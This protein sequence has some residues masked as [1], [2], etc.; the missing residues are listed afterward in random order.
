MIAQWALSRLF[1]ADLLFLMRAIIIIVLLLF[2]IQLTSLFAIEQLSLELGHITGLKWRA[3]Q[4]QLRFVL[5]S[6]S[7]D[8]DRFHISIGKIRHPLLAS[9]LVGT[10]IECS[11]G[12]VTQQELKCEQGSTVVNHSA[13]D[14][15]RLPMTF[16]WKYRPQ[17]IELKFQNIRFLDGKVA[18]SIRLDK[19]SWQGSLRGSELD[20]AKSQALAKEIADFSD[21][22]LSS[23]GSLNLMLNLAGDEAGRIAGNWR[24]SLSDLSFSA[25]SDSY[26]GEG[27]DAVW[28]GE[29]Q[30]QKNRWQGSQWL[31]MSKGAILTPLLYVGVEAAPITLESDFQLP[32]TPDSIR[33]NRL[34]FRHPGVAGFR[35]NARLN[36]GEILEVRQL[37]LKTDALSLKN[38]QE[39]YIQPA[40]AEPV[41]EAMELSGT[42]SVEFNINSGD[43]PLLSLQ[44]NKIGLNMRDAQTQSAQLL[45]F[46]DLSGTLVLPAAGISSDNRLSLA[47]G[48]LFEGIRLGAFE[49]NLRLTQWGLS[50]QQPVSIPVLDGALRVEDF[51]LEQTVTGPRVRFSGYLTPISM[52]ALSQALG[53]M[54]LAGRLSGMIPSISYEAGVIAVNGI[55]LIRMFGGEITIRNLTLDDLF[56]TFP[57]LEADVELKG[58][59]LETLTQR[60]SFGKI[61]G[62]LDGS[63]KGL[64]LEQWLPISFDA[65]FNT[66][67]GDKSKHR[68]SQ[69]AVE[70]I[71]D[72]GGAG[73]SGALSRS[74]LRF[75]DEFGYSRLGISCRLE[76][77]I[78]EMGGVEPAEQGYYLVKGGG[79]PR[80]DILGFNERT[81]WPLLIAKLKQISERGTKA[82]E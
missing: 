14:N 3:E 1:S 66:P 28:R 5:S 47:G 15:Q 82:T 35:A 29:I 72:L 74:L 2:C 54:P 63:V 33:L 75:F 65:R 51:S 45:E 6:N 70:N 77:N 49:L 21:L 22:Q 57:V 61:T 10:E 52:E 71:S 38:L 20:S 7:D 73:I 31:K 68:I 43:E 4:I 32:L 12:R 53:W 79:V 25:D 60:F 42:I 48:S 64:R 34:T 50:L 8:W 11:K 59:D 41:I 69:R 56:G 37:N 76:N 27:I 62:K 58:L 44:L 36:L 13:L 9:P 46:R 80:I 55:T 78:C 23:S 40:L 19:N 16:Y 30:L 26:I 67:M 24:V 81:D 39:S 17:Y 18:A